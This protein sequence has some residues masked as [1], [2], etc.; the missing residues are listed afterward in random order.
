MKKVS[1]ETM[2]TILDEFKSYVEIYEGSS[3]KEAKKDVKS[4]MNCIVILSS[5]NLLEYD[6]VKVCSKCGESKLLIEFQ[7]FSNRK[8]GVRPECKACN[9]KQKKVY[10]ESKKS[11]VVSK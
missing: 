4:I 1:L 5:R 11:L 8:S 9:S 10:R 6:N 7:K 3:K 2:K